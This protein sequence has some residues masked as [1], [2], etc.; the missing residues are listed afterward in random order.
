MLKSTMKH[1]RVM[2]ALYR[3]TEA[4]QSGCFLIVTQLNDVSGR[5]GAAVLE[6]GAKHGFMEDIRIWAELAVTRFF[7]GVRFVVRRLVGVPTVDA[8]P[9]P[10]HARRRSQS[11]NNVGSSHEDVSRLAVCSLSSVWVHLSSQVHLSLSGGCRACRD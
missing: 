6:A 8:G 2:L 4:S 9:A 10:A 5:A 3:T 11:E 1:L 7:D